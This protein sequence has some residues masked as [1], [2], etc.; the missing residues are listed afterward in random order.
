NIL[1]RSVNSMFGY[2]ADGIFKTQEEVTNH[3]SQPGKDIGRL[4]YKDLNGDGDI[5]DLD[6]TYIGVS[7]PLYEY[8]VNVALEYKKFDF[9]AF[10]QGVF[11]RDVN[12]GIKQRTDFSSLWAGINYGE[13]MLNAWTPDNPNAT[14]PA[15]T[16]VNDNNEG[17]MST[18]FVENGA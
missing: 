12:N 7:A 6:Q 16:L 2:V 15:A 10:F 5:N 14:I 8:G 13:R 1:G 17:R 4:R 9:S 18:Y 3:A 11:D